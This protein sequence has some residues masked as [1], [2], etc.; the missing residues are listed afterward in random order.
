MKLVVVSSAPFIYKE[1]RIYAYSPYVNELI[2]WQNHVDGIAF[3][4][5]SWPDDKGLLITEI[6]FKI[7]KQFTLIDFNV[8][9][10]LNSFKAFF[11]SLLNFF[12]IYQAMRS[13]N[14][15]HL[16]CP[17]NIGLLGSVVQVLFPKTPKTAKYA[18][19]W[20]PKSKQPWTYYLQKWIISNPLLTRNMQVLVYGE[21]EGSTPNIKPFFTATYTEADKV[22]V[23]PRKSNTTIHFIFVGTLVKGKH[24]LYAIQLVE[25]LHQQG[26]VVQLTLYG[27]GVLRT[28]LQQ[29]IDQ[30]HLQTLVRLEGNQAKET[31]KQA[32]QKSHFVVLPSDSEG[33]PKAIAE[34]M[35][36][37]CV[38]IATSVS[39]VPFMLDYGERGIL[40]EMNL[41]K[42][43]IQIK[44]LIQNQIDFES[45]QKRAM[46]WSREYTI[47][48]F[49]SEIKKMLL[50]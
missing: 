49:E 23:L 4:C 16:R 31:V 22:L 19:N 7:E 18:G 40:T 36:W 35:F 11:Y 29:Y 21:W 33:W 37:G 46:D 47:D 50:S 9:T 13:A 32:Y 17:G 26:H 10:V 38:P 12:V 14:H 2:I 1:N 27:D 15:I 20:D 39:C 8:T 5:P 24:P 25:Q 30:H 34:G 43:S 28:V 3:C 42:D 6:P 41:E 44:A 48:V 45:M